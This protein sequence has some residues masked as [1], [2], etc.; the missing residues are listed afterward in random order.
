MAQSGPDKYPVSLQ[1]ERDR[2]IELLSEHFAQDNLTLDQ[3]EQRIDLAYQA[4]AIPALRELTKDLQP[5]PG[6]VVARTQAPLPEAFAPDHDRIVSV[7]AQTTKRGMWQPPRS[8]DVWAVM[9]ET[10]LDLTEARLA[11]GVTEIHLR[12]IMATVK[13]IVP[14]GVRVVVQPSAFMAEVS[15]EAHTPPPLGSNAPVVRITGRVF[16]AELKVRVRSR[17]EPV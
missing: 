17:E 1:G 16:M 11:T 5:E 15:D 3:L 7:M 10:V 9:S 12:A 13:V 14:P 4:S 6:P 8:L 2:T